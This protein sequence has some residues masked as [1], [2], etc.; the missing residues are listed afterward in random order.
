MTCNSDVTAALLWK[1]TNTHMTG[2]IAKNLLIKLSVAKQLGSDCIPYHLLGKSHTLEALDKS[3]LAD[4]SKIEKAL[5]QRKMFE[6]INKALKLFFRGKSTVV[7]RKIEAL[8]N[9]ISHDKSSKS[10]F[11]ADLFDQICELEN[12]TNWEVI[13]SLLTSV[14]KSNQINLIQSLPKFRNQIN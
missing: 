8:L 10:S 5:K 13:F 2:S 12:F 3:N 9:Q 14:E 4:L 7:E 6:S 1:N 11:L